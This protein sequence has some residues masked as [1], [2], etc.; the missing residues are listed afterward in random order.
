MIEKILPISEDKMK[1]CTD[2]A[3]KDYQYKRI[4]EIVLCK[5]K[6]RSVVCI[7]STPFIAMGRR[8]FLSVYDY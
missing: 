8:C 4:M 6:E 2:Y 3:E 5:E 1:S 7:F